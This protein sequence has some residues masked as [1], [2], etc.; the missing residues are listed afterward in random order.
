V[1]T[2]WSRAIGWLTQ[3]LIELRPEKPG[4]P[5]GITIAFSWRVG[6]V[7]RWIATGREIEPLGFV[8]LA[9]TSTVPQVIDAAYPEPHGRPVKVGATV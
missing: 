8:R 4:P 5:A 7:D 1:I 3:L 6:L 2:S 9:G